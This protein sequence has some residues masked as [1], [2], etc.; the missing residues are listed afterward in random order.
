M[1]VWLGARKRTA[2]VDGV[3]QSGDVMYYVDNEFVNDE[4]TNL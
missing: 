3:F 1:D 4:E 2:D